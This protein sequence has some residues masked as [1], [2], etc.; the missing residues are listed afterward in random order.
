MPRADLGAANGRYSGDPSKPVASGV[1]SL[2]RDPTRQERTDTSDHEPDGLLER[3]ELR[4][5]LV[6]NGGVSLAIW[7]SGVVAELDALR[8]ADAAASV[9]ANEGDGATSLPIYAALLEALRLRVRIDVIAGT[10]AGGLNGG[11]LGTA[12]AA[13][14][15]YAEVRAL[16]LKLGDLASLFNIVK[17][18]Q[19]R[20]ISILKG[21][22]VMYGQL[23]ARF[24]EVLEDAAPPDEDAEGSGRRVRLILTGT[25]VAGVARL[26][27]DSFG[28]VLQI[29]D[30]RLQARF[31]H[32]G[33][34]NGDV[35]GGWARLLPKEVTAPR[36]PIGE[37]V[38]RAARTSASFPIGFEPSKL[39]LAADSDRRSTTVLGEALVTRDGRNVAEA[40]RQPGA[41][42]NV[43]LTR[44]PLDGGLLDNSPIGAVLGTITGLSAQRAVQRTV[45]FVVPYTDDLPE[46]P[47]V[48]PASGKCSEPRSTCRA[49][50]RSWTISKRSSTTSRGAPATARR[51]TRCSDCRS[52]SSSASPTACTRRS[53]ACGPARR[54]GR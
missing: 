41:P 27:K 30:H 24:V 48:Q 37:A 25:D 19:P 32:G 46:D 1:S 9:A 14:R 8:R 18:K 52:T 28:D 7:I 54:S 45:V 17:R 2:R 38:A 35:P 42:P 33:D 15:P 3:D 23:R 16:W 29:V 51:S 43:P 44:W 40:M 21:E 20:P 49:T 5:A 10:S 4:L 39:V 22:E 6:L 11:L 26:T 31:A 53:G 13:G 47:A 12:I 50:W 36:D 34:A